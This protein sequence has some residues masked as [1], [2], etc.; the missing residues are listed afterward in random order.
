MYLMVVV[1][2]KESFKISSEAKLEPQVLGESQ[3]MRAPEKQCSRGGW[4]S[5]ITSQNWLKY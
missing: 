3:T 4:P 2:Y 5:T 1:V